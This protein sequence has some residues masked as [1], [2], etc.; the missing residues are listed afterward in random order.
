ME[1]ISRD[2]SNLP[3]FPRHPLHIFWAPTLPSGPLSWPPHPWILLIL[4]ELQHPPSLVPPSPCVNFPLLLSGWYAAPPGHPH[5]IPLHSIQAA[6]P[7]AG[8]PS[9]L[10]VTLLTSSWFLGSRHPIL[11]PFRGSIPTLLRFLHLVLGY[12]LKQM[13]SSPHA[14]SDTC[15]GP[16]RLPSWW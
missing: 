9:P 2:Y 7:L 13:L 4:F 10:A 16:S 3:Y 15:C 6:I 11:C 8:P 14:G 5:P 1:T 12:L